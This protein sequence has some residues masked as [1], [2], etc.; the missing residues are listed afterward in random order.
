MRKSLKSLTLGVSAAL[1]LALLF[2][3]CPQDSD[4]D[5]DGG[6]SWSGESYQKDLDGIAVA[7]A[8]GAK[9][10]YLKD[11]LHLKDGELIVPWEKEL[12][13]TRKV[14]IDQIGPY[15]KLV[16]A[17]NI[18]FTPNN[19][20]DILLY[21]TPGAKLI[22]TEAFVN[23]NVDILDAPEDEALTPDEKKLRHIKANQNQIIKFVT[24]DLA[25]EEAWK[26]NINTIVETSENAGY[27]P[28]LIQSTGP[29]EIGDKI[30]ANISKYGSG[31]RVYLISGVKLLS[32]IVIEAELKYDPTTIESVSGA[33][34]NAIPDNNGSLVIG[35][36]TEFN[37][38]FATVSTASGLT[39][40]GTLTTS[41]DRNFALVT[42]SGPLVTYVLRLENGGGVFGGDVE[43][44]G[45]LP[46]NLGAS[47]AFKANFKTR[48]SIVIDSV[49]FDGETVLNGPIEFKGNKDSVKK[50]VDATITLNGPVT[51]SNADPVNVADNQTFTPGENLTS[52]TY[53]F[54]YG[55]TG[56]VSFTKEVIFND[57]A[58]FGGNTEYT[59]TFENGVAFNSTATFGD[60]VAPSFTGGSKVTFA[61]NVKI[62][63]SSTVTFGGPVLFN[64]KF[65]RTG[66]A[67]ADT[68]LTGGATFSNEA[69]FPAGGKIIFGS[70]SNTNNASL[71]FNSI[72]I[73]A[74]GENG[75]AGTLTP[76]ADT[77]NLSNGELTLGEGSLS[78]EDAEIDISGGGKIVIKPGNADDYFNNDSGILFVTDE[79][80]ITAKGYTIS[81]GTVA[82]GRLVGLFAETKGVTLGARAITGNGDGTQAALV[83]A[84]TANPNGDFIPAPVLTVLDD[85]EIEGVTLD[86]GGT[87]A[88]VSGGTYTIG[89][90]SIDDN[91]EGNPVIIL[92]GGS[93]TVANGVV[94]SG[95]VGG[96]KVEGSIGVYG[97]AL[98]TGSTYIPTGYLVGN[99]DGFASGTASAGTYT[100][101]VGSKGSLA[102]ATVETITKVTGGTDVGFAV[103]WGGVTGEKDAVGVVTSS[104]NNARYFD[105]GN[106]GGSVA[107]F[108]YVPAPSGN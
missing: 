19:E 73:K 74:A 89:S 94:N 53:D 84:G 30:A 99:T 54:P 93:A 42:T 70:V 108:K 79:S 27:I 29:Y 97:Q 6:S 52:Y 24:F 36:E 55:T 5:D 3:G 12:D 104:G 63:T 80:K 2:L 41:G 32:K 39:V 86:L 17:G 45:S 4:D 31:R 23:S 1:L 60:K 66:N 103:Y 72:V 64:G 7:F 65:E 68:I 71:V 87:V 95:A 34:F 69:S 21:K 85:I 13:L 62:G 47:A 49:S 43:V 100:A 59:V 14:T 107:V 75:T 90:I 81:A 56:A 57:T 67:T 46:S 38:E 25:D 18:N 35:G 9:T 78:L 91:V 22:A 28:I 101:N 98:N 96:I 33:V 82:T 8:D 44:I 105:A 10:V 48:G 20:Y 26:T 50:S 83:F 76:V 106:A 16:V 77:I 102:T 11:N 40:L 51:L 61:K 15:G 88:E 92:K 58:T 37:G